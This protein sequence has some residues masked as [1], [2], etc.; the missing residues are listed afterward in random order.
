MSIP[1]AAGSVF[2]RWNSPGTLRPAAETKAITLTN[3]D[4]L[5]NRKALA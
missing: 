5:D 4:A 2:L 1:F 3:G